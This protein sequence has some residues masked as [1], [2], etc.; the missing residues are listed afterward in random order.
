MRPGL[1]K[2]DL[3]RPLALAVLLSAGML[4]AQRQPA[5]QTAS[6]TNQGQLDGSEALFTVLAAMNAAGYDANLDSNAN[7]PVRKRLRETIASKHLDSVDALKK[8]IA[9]HHQDDPEAE[10]SQYMSFALSI[11]GPPDFQFWLLPQEIPPDVRKL[12]GLNELIAN[13]YLEAG[14]GNLWKQS[15]PELEQVIEAY[16]G[17]VTQAV[18]ETSAYLRN[19]TSGFRDRRFQIYVDLLGAPNQIQTRSYRERYFVVVTPSP[20][21][22]ID[23]VRHAYLHY[24]LDPY[25]LRYFEQWNR[26]KGLA[27]Y[28]QPSPALDEAYKNDLM[29]FATECVIKAV[30]SRLAHGAQNKEALVNQALS[31]GFVL[32]PALADGLAVYEKQ[33]ESLRIYF[34]DLIGKIDLERE[35]RRLQKVEFAKEATVHKAKAAPAPP[36]PVLSESAKTLATAEDLY[37]NRD[38]PRARETYRK[39]LELPAEN[40]V[41]AR[42]YYGLARIAALDRDPE[43]AE[44]LFQKTLEMSPDDDTKSW[45]YLYLGRLSDAAGEREQAEKHYRAALAVHGAPEQVKVAAEKGLAQP[46]QR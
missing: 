25:S 7:S 12:D 43:L 35:D 4:Q 41:H 1:V 3:V 19:P 45:A 10:L 15:Q 2:L 21:P 5:S 46:F 26:V 36:P 30:E 6:Q 39:V 13:F 24:L 44:K 16:H 28:A 37:G 9:G 32:T 40:P 8:F 31:Q 27:E 17:G 38:L 34:P 29:L 14:I 33:P 18:L 42:A 22:Q 11:E 23:Q 20:E